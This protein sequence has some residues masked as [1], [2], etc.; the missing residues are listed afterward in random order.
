MHAKCAEVI[1][2]KRNGHKAHNFQKLEKYIIRKKHLK[3]QFIPK[4]SGER[5]MEK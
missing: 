2:R 5:R 1:T 4:D 3:I